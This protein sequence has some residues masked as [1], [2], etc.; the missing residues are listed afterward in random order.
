MARLTSTPQD[1]ESI[2]SCKDNAVIGGRINTGTMDTPV[3]C[4]TFPQ[5]GAVPKANIDMA[6]A[7]AVV[8]GFLFVLRKFSDRWR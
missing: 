5:D 8:L 7:P 2:L 3:Q 6:D 4:I 1:V